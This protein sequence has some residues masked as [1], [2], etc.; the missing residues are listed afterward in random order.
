MQFELDEAR[1]DEELEVKM[2]LTIGPKS[3]VHLKVK[4]RSLVE[5]YVCATLQVLVYMVTVLAWIELKLDDKTSRLFVSYENS[6]CS[7][8]EQGCSL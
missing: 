1:R 3:G 5:G 4:A 7:R 2:V 6:N 8:T